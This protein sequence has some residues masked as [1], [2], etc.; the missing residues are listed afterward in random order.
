MK[1]F[2]Y[3]D[4]ILQAAVIFTAAVLFFIRPITAGIVLF[5]GL[6]LWDLLSLFVNLLLPVPQ[7]W[8]RR[9]SA[10]WIHTAAPITL[11]Y[12]IFLLDPPVPVVYTHSL[13]AAVLGIHYLFLCCR[14][15][16]GL[17]ELRDQV[18]LIDVQHH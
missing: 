5:F 14:E 2:K 6:L 12:G 10:L 1:T 15:L 7:K 4:I 3:I 11:S 17:R 18:M 13:Y 9:R 8:R 16:A